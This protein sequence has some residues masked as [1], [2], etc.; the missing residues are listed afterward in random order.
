MTNEQ[1]IMEHIYELEQ[2]LALAKSNI[3]VSAYNF[4]VEKALKACL[5]MTRNFNYEDYNSYLIKCFKECKIDTQSEDF[6]TAIIWTTMK[7]ASKIRV[8]ECMAE[9]FIEKIIESLNIVKVEDKWPLIR[10]VTN[11]WLKEAEDEKEYQIGE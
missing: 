4:N 11:L 1:S 2:E 8:N 6:N 5:I 10:K 3:K 7:W 9:Y